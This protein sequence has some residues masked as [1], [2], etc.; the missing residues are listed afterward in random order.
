MGGGS[1]ERRYFAAME[2]VALSPPPPSIGLVFPSIEYIFLLFNFLG[3][4]L[5]VPSCCLCRWPCT[6]A[7]LHTALV[8]GGGGQNPPSMYFIFE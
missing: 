7:V 8:G 4:V 3:E 5:V 2:S 6:R 1:W